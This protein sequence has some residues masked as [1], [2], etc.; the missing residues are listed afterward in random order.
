MRGKTASLQMDAPLGAPNHTPELCHT[1][2][3]LGIAAQ[4]P[5]NCC[6]LVTK[7]WVLSNARRRF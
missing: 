3:R 5:D 2:D 6:N 4:I 1:G 7:V